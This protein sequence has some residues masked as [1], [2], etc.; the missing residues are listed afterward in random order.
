[1]KSRKIWYLFLFLIF[2]ALFIAIAQLPEEQRLNEIEQEL[3]ALNQKLS[4]ELSPEERGHLEQRIGNLM[5]EK[6]RT[7][8]TSQSITGR[9]EPIASKRGD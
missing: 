8:G 7:G 9:R 2:S 5:A 1:M 3:N 6:N 4:E